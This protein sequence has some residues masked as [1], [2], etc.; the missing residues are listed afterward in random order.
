VG[1][2]FIPFQEVRIMRVSLKSVLAGIALSVLGLS[3]SAAPLTIS[4]T[5]SESGFTGDQNAPSYP[6]TLPTGY[7]FT[8][9]NANTLTTID[10]LTVTL[11]VVDGDTGP[12]DFDENNLTLGL[13]GIDTGIKLNG[14]LNNQIVTLDLTGN[15]ALAGA[16]LAALQADNKLVGT[17]IDATPGN[18]PQ[19]DLIGFPRTLDTTLSI[20][21]QSGGGGN[22][23]PLPLGLVVA[24]LGVGMAGIYSRRF[25]RQK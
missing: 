5:V 8:G 17:V 9:Q 10:S 15:P 12:G 24:P 13:D 1:L 3:A 22:P 25:R 4:S 21:G 23:V 7:D 19:G 6:L 11:S 18:A 16:L 2:L 20:T 14:F